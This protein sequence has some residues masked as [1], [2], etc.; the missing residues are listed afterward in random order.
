MYLL[1]YL[2]TNPFCTVIHT[3]IAQGSNMDVPSPGRPAGAN[4]PNNCP[5]PRFEKPQPPWYKP[6]LR[7]CEPIARRGF[8][9]AAVP[10]I[11]P[12]WEG[13]VPMPAFA[14][15]P[16]PQQAYLLMQIDVLIY[17]NKTNSDKYLRLL[18]THSHTHT[19]AHTHTQ[20]PT[21]T[22]THT[23]T[24]QQRQQHNML[25]LDTYVCLICKYISI[26]ILTYLLTRICMYIYM[27]LH[28]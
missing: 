26:R 7:I 16:W 13:D 27:Y 2:C 1:N 25:E 23:H 20:T 6:P 14:W 21:H 18:H 10:W 5:W 15:R 4:P 17:T 24:H 3:Y 9:S 8:R 11:E 22:N 12:P 28:M 19:L